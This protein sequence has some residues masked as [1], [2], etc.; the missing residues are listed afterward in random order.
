MIKGF[1]YL[2][3]I[4]YG[5]YHFFFKEDAPTPPTKVLSKAEKLEVVKAF[6][7]E[8][9]LQ[10]DGIIGNQTCNAISNNSNVQGVSYIIDECQKRDITVNSNKP[11]TPP[12]VQTKHLVEVL[13]V[14]FYPNWKG[15]ENSII[16]WVNSTAP[17]GCELSKYDI[18]QTDN[19]LWLSCDGVS[20]R[21]SFDK[22]VNGSTDRIQA[23][24]SDSAWMDCR[25]RL[26]KHVTDLGWSR[27]KYSV[28]NNATLKQSTHRAD[29]IS[30]KLGGK[31]KNVYNREVVAI[32]ICT[33]EGTKLVDFTVQEE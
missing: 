6:Q 33:Y 26:T 30:V 24:S 11:A 9:G 25:E 3:A 18:G 19:L 15:H 31:T 29:S 27:P 20:Y 13:D 1:F 23:I 4:I 28:L 32:G 7:S 14:E 17:Q 5:V 16:N 12:Q 10:A 2:I 8:Q 22:V 21:Q